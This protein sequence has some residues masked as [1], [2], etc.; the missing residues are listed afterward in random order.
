METKQG[1]NTS[2]GIHFPLTRLPDEDQ[3]MV[4][5]L[6]LY[7]LLGYL[8]TLFERVKHKAFLLTF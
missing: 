5:F 2:S 6:I 1:C 3:G 4:F 8:R 7:L